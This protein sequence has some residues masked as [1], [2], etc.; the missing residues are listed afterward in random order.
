MLVASGMGAAGVEMVKPFE[1]LEQ[2]RRFLIEFKK[3]HR[4]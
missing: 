2:T 3:R 4:R 1:A